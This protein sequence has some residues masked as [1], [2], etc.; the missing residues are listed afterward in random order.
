MIFLLEPPIPHNGFMKICPGILANTKIVGKCKIYP[1]Y[2]QIGLIGSPSYHFLRGHH[3]MSHMLYLQSISINKNTRESN[4]DKSGEVHLLRKSAQF[5][6]Q[7]TMHRS[8][9]SV[10]VNRT[11]RLAALW[12]FNRRTPGILLWV[13]RELLWV[14][15]S[16]TITPSK[17]AFDHSPHLKNIANIM[18]IFPRG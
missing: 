16:Y 12:F 4:N 3:P 10:A 18:N 15:F 1:K 6:D 11:G 9:N 13:F 7:F 8:S 5:S 17:L 2:T 14:E